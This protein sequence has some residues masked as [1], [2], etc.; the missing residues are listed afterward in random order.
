MITT[1][2]SDDTTAVK[3]RVRK[4]TVVDP[5]LKKF[6]DGA[7]VKTVR[8]SKD[9]GGTWG[10]RVYGPASIN[11]NGF[12]TEAAAYKGWAEDTFGVAEF[13]SLMNLFMAEARLTYI[14]ESLWFGGA[15]KETLAGCRLMDNPKELIAF[16]DSRLREGPK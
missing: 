1:N 9:W 8:C 14:M 3:T 16:V 13:K 12:R 5:M 15:D 10:Y 7:G 6:A 2:M 11:V 4:S